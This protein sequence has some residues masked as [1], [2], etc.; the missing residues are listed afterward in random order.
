M[1]IHRSL[2]LGALARCR[3]GAGWLASWLASWRLFQVVWPSIRGAD[4]VDGSFGGRVR[5]ALPDFDARG[6]ERGLLMSV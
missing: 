6:P 3:L 4:G 1:V 5:G 2:R